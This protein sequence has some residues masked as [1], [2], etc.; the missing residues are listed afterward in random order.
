MTESRFPDVSVSGTPRASI[1]VNMASR[2]FPGYSRT[3][4]VPGAIPDGRTEISSGTDFTGFPLPQ[5]VR[6]ASRF[7]R[8]GLMYSSYPLMSERNPSPYGGFGSVPSPLMS[9][10]AAG[11]EMSLHPAFFRQTALNT[12]APAADVMT[13]IMAQITHLAMMMSRSRDPAG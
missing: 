7:F 10:S 11:E 4:T 13:N 9:V 2:A 6:K 12:S 3:E 1:S 8:I 5:T